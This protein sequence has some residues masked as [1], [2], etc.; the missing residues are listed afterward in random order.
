MP[1]GD[2]VYLAS[3]RLNRALAGNK[4]TRTDFRVPRYATLDLSGRAVDEVTSRG[5]HM[6]F[7][8]SGDVTIHTHFKMDGSWELYRVGQRW[9]SPGSQARLV[10]STTS[11]TAVGF[12][13]PVIEVLPRAEEEQVI[14]HL[15]PDPLRNWDPEEALRRLEAAGPRPIGEALLDQS[16]I[17]GLGNVYKSEICFL[18]GVHPDALVEQ[19]DD[20]GAVV[21][22][23]ARLLEANRTTG[24]QITTGDPRR[25][26]TSWVYGRG[27][28]ACRRCG[29]PVQKKQQESYGVDRV[30]YWCPSCQPSPES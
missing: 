22:L 12:R 16:V 7:R 25:G 18:R 6:L 19:V 10:L 14:G 29:A 24:R 27:G 4:L 30:T 8:L 17:A 11:W 21:S 15:G 13:L 2:T 5:K 3:T 20:L 28:Q 9:R 26:Q 1:E 23:A